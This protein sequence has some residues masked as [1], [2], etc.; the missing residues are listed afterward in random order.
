M[1][2]P[3]PDLAV[4]SIRLYPDRGNFQAGEAVLISV[5]I[6]NQGNGTAAP[7]WVDL[8][9][10]PSSLPTLNVPWNETCAAK[11]PC[12]GLVWKLSEALPPGQSITLTSS[13]GNY[14]APYSRWAGW[15]PAGTTSVYVLADSWNPNATVG[16]SGDLNRDNNLRVLQGLTVSGTN[17]PTVSNTLS[18]R[19]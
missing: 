9:L 7:F 12:Y 5:T 19:E 11:D 18:T 6:T 17:P 8:Y 14:A 16:A 1:L 2:S 13:I 3:R 15:L 10:N 4:T